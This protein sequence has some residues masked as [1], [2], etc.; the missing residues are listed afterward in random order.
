MKHLTYFLLLVAVA[1][2][3]QTVD[4]EKTHDVSKEA[5]KG[6]IHIINSDLEKKQIEVI[7][8]V[9]A[10]KNQAKF[11]TYTFDSDFNFI[12]ESE[13]MVDLEKELPK[14][15]RQK[16]Y[17]G[18]NFSQEGLAV[19][20]NMMGTLVLKRKVTNFKWSWFY[21]AYNVTVNVAEKLKA[22]TDDDKKL[23]YHDHI[24]DNTTGTALILAGEK[25]TI[26]GGPYNHLMNYH[27][28]KYD[29][30][31]TKLAD[32]TVNFET[33]QQVAAVY[34]YPNTEDDPKSD[35][36]A[37][38]AP[39]KA[40]N[41]VGPKIWSPT[42]NEYT[43]VRVS[44]DGKLLD[45]VSFTAPNSIWRIDDFILAKDGS[46]YFYGPSNDEQDE[47]FQ[48]RL[49]YNSNEKKKWPMFQLAKV[50]NGKVVFAT[51]TSM[52]DFEKKLKV[53]PD[54]KKGDSY[55]GRRVVFTESTVSPN[56]DFVLAGQGYGMLRNAK[57]Q[58][59]GR[60]YEDLL[61]FHFDSKGNL[62][63]Q[64]TMNKKFKGTSPDH[65]YFEFS[66]DGKSLFWTLFD[67]TGTKNVKELD[68]VVEK[69]LAVPKLAKINLAT[70]T[71]DKYTE[72]GKGENFVHYGGVSKYALTNY[73]K[74]S[75]SNKVA[76]FGE[77]K[78][79][80][81]LWFVRVNFDQ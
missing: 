53:Q 14:K 75:D 11:I 15:Y 55:N 28:L 44:Y 66:S 30:N 8:R 40:K 60:T 26:K 16:K 64:Y 48:T 65:Q 77:N 6:F 35:M 17:R 20:P 36:I 19:E 68:L 67:V 73:F 33:P 38:F 1:A 79:G 34:G 31:L 78:K 25:G 62:V 7:Y 76:Y 70:G 50:Q 56:G 10:K 74:Y 80:S 52:D 63:S 37:I 43:Y 13:E 18:E 47:Y 81:S 59:I 71:F 23:F 58:A 24:E 39:H 61:M 54:G 5:M 69:P 3:A 45:K 41:Y 49:E 27:F 51:K 42:A 29:V 4:I 2:N 32:V 21:G 72:F 12:S 9:R 22:K 46:V 57:G